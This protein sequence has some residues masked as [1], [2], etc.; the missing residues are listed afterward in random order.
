[1]GKVESNM[2]INSL[3]FLKA[4]ANYNRIA[5]SDG[6]AMFAPVA[7]AKCHKIE[8]LFMVYM[9]DIFN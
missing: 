8:I 1:V 7:L 3:S 2:V 9:Y 5:C 4:K 6:Q